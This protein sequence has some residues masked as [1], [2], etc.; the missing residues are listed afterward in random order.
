MCEEDK[1][2]FLKIIVDEFQ[3]F[4]FISRSTTH[5]FLS[6]W[7]ERVQTSFGLFWAL[8]QMMLVKRNLRIIG[9]QVDQFLLIF[10]S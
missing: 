5:L 7:I 10:F 8:C 9:D 2:T 1:K 3:G 4:D 6:L